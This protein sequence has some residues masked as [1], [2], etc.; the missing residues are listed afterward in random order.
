[1]TRNVS[2]AMKQYTS[3]YQTLEKG[4]QTLTDALLQK[5]GLVS[6]STPGNDM[7]E[8][9]AFCVNALVKSIDY[10]ELTNDF[11]LTLNHSELDDSI[12]PY[13]VTCHRL[14]LAVPAGSLEK[15]QWLDYFQKHPNRWDQVHTLEADLRLV[16]R[17]PLLKFFVW[18]DKKWWLKDKDEEKALVD[19]EAFKVFTDS[20]L[21]QLYFYC[22]E[23]DRLSEEPSKG[24]MTVYPDEA[25]A[26]YWRSVATTYEGDKKHFYDRVVKKC[27]GLN[28][29]QLRDLSEISKKYEVSPQFW[30]RALDYL[31]EL[32]SIERKRVEDSALFAALRDWMEPPFYAGWHSWAVG[33]KPW[34][35]RRRMRKPFGD[36]PLFICGEAFSVEQG[37]GEG[38]LRSAEAVLLDKEIGFGLPEPTFGKIGAEIKNTRFES[39]EEYVKF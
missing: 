9:R 27:P 12:K 13:K 1:M 38:A 15:L 22:G 39:I 23:R 20:S 31:C 3:D 2:L 28:A 21:R 33:C 25:Y 34:D 29:A 7:G 11:I 26:R 18:F 24:L 37:W 30:K 36:L 16:N 6:V 8:R 35:I 19:E 4:M 17:H 32:F 5:A 14:V 10:D